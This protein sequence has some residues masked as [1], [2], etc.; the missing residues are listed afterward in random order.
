L[1]ENEFTSTLYKMSKKEVLLGPL[2]AAAARQ[3]EA[4]G[5]IMQV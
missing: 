4:G 5:T 2:A 3:R 1:N